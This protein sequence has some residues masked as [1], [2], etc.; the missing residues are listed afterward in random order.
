MKLLKRIK[1]SNFFL[2]AKGKYIDTYELHAFGVGLI[3]SSLF[4]VPDPRIQK[5]STGMMVTLSG[6]ALGVEGV[7]E[8][9]H[10]SKV[11]EVAL[12]TTIPLRRQIE[13]EGQYTLLGLAT[14]HLT[15]FG[16]TFLTSLI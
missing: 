1:Q 3:A 11:A 15:V 13:K 6:I 12:D 2:T 8:K 4:Y 9:K 14:P 7:K 5:L 16:V 10:R